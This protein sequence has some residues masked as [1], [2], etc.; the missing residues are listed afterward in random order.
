MASDEGFL[1]RT[2][3]A[4]DHEQMQC[5][6][7]NNCGIAQDISFMYFEIFFYMCQD[8]FLDSFVTKCL[9]N[10]WRIPSSIFSFLAMDDEKHP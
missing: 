10:T 4:A 7:C 5:W 6:T 9:L 1:K 2:R 8:N 3:I